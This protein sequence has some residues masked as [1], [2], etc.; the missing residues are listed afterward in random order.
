ML[1][2]CGAETAQSPVN[3]NGFLTGIFSRKNRATD[4][5]EAVRSPNFGV[6]LGCRPSPPTIHMEDRAPRT[7]ASV[8]D[9][10]D[11]RAYRGASPILP[12][13]PVQPDPC[14]DAFKAWT[15]HEAREHLWPA[16][17]F[18]NWVPGTMPPEADRLPIDDEIS[19]LLAPRAIRSPRLRPQAQILPLSR[20][21]PEP[22]AGLVSS[23]GV[24]CPYREA[25][26]YWLPFAIRTATIEFNR[27]QSRTKFDANI[28]ADIEAARRAL[29]NFCRHDE[30]ALAREGRP[31]LSGPEMDMFTL[32]PGAPLDPLD[33]V[34]FV[35][36][37]IHPVMQAVCVKN[38]AYYALL[39]SKEALS[40]I[41]TLERTVKAYRRL[42]RVAR[43]HQNEWEISFS[44]ALGFAWRRFTGR[45]PSPSPASPFEKF[46][47]AAY[48]SLGKSRRNVSWDRACRAACNRYRGKFNYVDV[49]PA[50]V[51]A[52]HAVLGRY[53]RNAA[54]ADLC[55]FG[56]N[57]PAY[58]S[59][60]PA[61]R[62]G[63]VRPMNH[64][65]HGDVHEEVELHHRR[66]LRDHRLGANIDLQRHSD[67]QAEGQEAREEEDTH[68]RGSRRGLSER[69]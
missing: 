30:D 37:E 15:Y 64:Q 23:I 32:K 22:F 59:S 11:L 31:I 46:V 48:S 42:F 55:G 14:P 28:L 56:L 45:D 5:R 69:P 34:K 43:S 58:P 39:K 38:S 33:M 47:H 17:R 66:I 60:S 1:A 49:D 44:S 29:T 35:M 13:M 6:V 57:F 61:D 2:G 51:T 63:M 50:L 52:G 54:F 36:Q 26:S 67:G 19:R 65:E 12:P 16:A 62:F 40:D 10:K 18:A 21:L 9:W 41:E 20:G 24:F 8:T 4:C 27:L 7:W 3:D 25:R 68:S 53:P